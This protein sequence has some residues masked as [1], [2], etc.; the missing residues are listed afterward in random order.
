PPRGRLLP[1]AGRR[2]RGH[3]L[4]GRRR[5]ARALAS[6]GARVAE[7]DRAEVRR[8]ADGVRLRPPDVS[9]A[10]TRRAAHERSSRPP[11]L[12]ACTPGAARATRTGSSA[13]P[14]QSASR[15]AWPPTSIHSIAGAPGHG[16]GPG[17]P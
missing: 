9:G 7:G 5:P 11:T 1:A 14:S 4:R 16:T 8:H 15:G 17:T 13:P 2:G 12:S 10:L 3:V 6:D